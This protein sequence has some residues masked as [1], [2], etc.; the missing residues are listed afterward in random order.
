MN[1]NISIEMQEVASITEFVER[2]FHHKFVQD[3]YERNVRRNVTV[4]S[5]A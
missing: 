5:L 3:R 4:H 2:H 1:L